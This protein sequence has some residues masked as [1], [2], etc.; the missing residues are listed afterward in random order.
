[1]LLIYYN[2]A[3]LGGSMS[4]LIQTSA[5]SSNETNL[6]FKLLCPQPL[7]GMLIGRGGSIIN[8]LNISTGAKINLS[9]NEV[10]FPTTND[11]ILVGINNK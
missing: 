11:R 10:Y 5:H 4:Q 2:K 1:M 8:Q 7:T 3:A 6:Y 9:Q